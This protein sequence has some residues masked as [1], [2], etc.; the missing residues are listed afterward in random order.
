MARNYVKLF[1]RLHNEEMSE[2][3][4]EEMDREIEH[5]ME[6]CYMNAEDIL[7]KHNETLHKLANELFTYKTLNSTY[8][9]KGID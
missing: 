5:I 3:S 4:K 2:Y 6:Y 7:W 1:G 9:S 8:L